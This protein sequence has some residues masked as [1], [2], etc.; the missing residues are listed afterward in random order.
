MAANTFPLTVLYVSASQKSMNN[1]PLNK[2]KEPGSWPGQFK[3][4]IILQH[5]FYVQFVYINCY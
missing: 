1:L 2:F 4:Q 5:H 3:C